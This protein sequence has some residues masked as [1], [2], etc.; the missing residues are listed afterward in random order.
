MT[1]DL[2]PVNEFAV[3]VIWPMPH[4]ESE[5]ID[6]AGGTCFAS[7][8]FVSGY[9]KLPLDPATAAAHSIITPNAMYTPSR[10][11]QGASNSCTNFQANVEPIFS[12]IREHLKAWLDDFVL[13]CK[14]EEQLLRA[15]RV[16]P[17]HA[18][19]GR[20]NTPVCRNGR[21]SS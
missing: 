5:E 4:L 3:P 1:I 20:R 21:P 17:L 7:I 9:W 8:E 11:L 13:H 2:R 10:T 15:L 18:M 12:D 6:F 19:D 14:S 16:C